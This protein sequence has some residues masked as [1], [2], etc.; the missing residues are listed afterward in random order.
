MKDKPMRFQLTEQQWQD[1]LP[2]DTFEITRHA[3]TERPFT[4]EYNQLQGEGRYHCSCCFAPLF[5]AEHQYISGCGWPSFDTAITEYV[6]EREDASL[7]RIRTEIFCNACD[8]HIGHVFPDGPKETTGMRHCVNSLSVQFYPQQHEIDDFI[9]LLSSDNQSAFD[10]AQVI[11]LI[12]KFF[13]FT[14]SVFDNGSQ[15]NQAGEN[16]GSCKVLS[17]AH[18]YGLNKQQTLRCF[19][20]HYQSV[21]DNP[22]GNDHQN[23]RQFIEHGWD[24]IVFYG[25]ALKLK[26]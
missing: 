25:V 14:P 13:E 17:F 16:K 1:R 19:A 18:Q 7:A 8:S 22:T 24:G 11:T 20:E 6:G 12:D 21:V 9:K 26:I 2:V 3:D 15:Q 5:A 23:I 4:G 10:F